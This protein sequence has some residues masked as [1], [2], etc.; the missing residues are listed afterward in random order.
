MARAAAGTFSSLSVANYRRYIAGQSVSLIGTW[1]QSVAQGWLVL[2]LTDSASWVGVVVGL[3]TLPVLLLGPYGG[4]IADRADKRRLLAA[5]QAAKGVNSLLLGILVLTG[6]VRLW[7]VCVLALAFGIS[8]VFDTPVRQ[9]FVNEMVG[10]DHLRNAVSLNSV[11]VNVGRAVGP[12]LAGLIIAAAGVGPCFLIDAAS[13]I[14]VITSLLTL[15]RAALTPAPRTPRARGQF[16][17]GIAYVRSVPELLFP[18]L[19]MAIVGMLAYE[20][21]VVLPAL[22][23]HTFH[24]GAGAFGLMTAAMGAG[25]IVGGLGVASRGRAGLG[26]LSLA[27]AVFGLMIGASAAAPT[28]PIA[29]IVLV[30]TGAAS[31][32]FLALTTTTLQLTSKPQMRGRVMSLWSV[33]ILGSTPI[34][35]PLIGLVS[36]HAGPRVGLLV[37]AGA[38][39]AAAA[40][41]ASAQVR[42]RRASAVATG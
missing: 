27:A 30:P 6:T 37:G 8:N 5:V 20:F 41:G 39:L 13:Y 33:A 4:V 26:P 36:Q 34:G 28:L 21:G 1:M 38:C 40:L 18:L 32:V 42:V 29:L 25:A 12:A 15:E 35:G 17:E 3:Q 31:V 23:K 7:M 14:A 16:R 19:M 2:E 22:A 24:A 11:M 9:S 10:P